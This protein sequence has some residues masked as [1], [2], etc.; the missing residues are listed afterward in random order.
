[1]VNLRR[2]DAGASI[3]IKGMFLCFTWQL[4]FFLFFGVN[5]DLNHRGSVI[6]FEEIRLID[7]KYYSK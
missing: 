2:S 3:I 1:M 7:Y 5:L 6:F 4:S